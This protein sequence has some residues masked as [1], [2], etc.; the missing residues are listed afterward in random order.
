MDSTP[1][2]RLSE[3]SH[4]F[5]TSLRDK[6]TGGA[7]RPTRIPPGVHDPSGFNP[8]DHMTDDA[9]LKIGPPARERGK[10]IS[11]DLTP[12]E[13]ALAF[14]C[15]DDDADDSQQAP[16]ATPKTKPLHAVLA[17]HLGDSMSD[18]L[19]AYAGSLCVDG[20]RVGVIVADASGLRVSCVER[21]PHIDPHSE[22][23]A[24]V[25]RADDRQMRETLTE[26]NCDVDRWLLVLPSPK[27]GEARA[28]LKTVNA[29][30]LLCLTDHD[31]VTAAYRA[32]KGLADIGRPTV[33]VAPLR[34]EDVI[35]TE[36]AF[37]K[38]SSVCEQFLRLPLALGK[39]VVSAPDVAEHV[40]MNYTA[41]SD[42]A[43]FSAAPQWEVVSQFA[44]SAVRDNPIES[45]TSAPAAAPRP[46]MAIVPE[47]V[48]AAGP[49][50]PAAPI[51]FAS[52][53]ESVSMT[54]A[55]AAEG[56]TDVLELTGGATADAILRAVLQGGNDLAECPLRAPA[57]PEAVIAVARD[58]SLTLLAVARQGLNELRAIAI[59]YRWLGDNRALIA[60]ALPQF[61]TDTTAL[62]RLHLL[63]DQSDMTADIL[64]PLLAT[65][66]VTVRAYRKLRWGNK[67]GLLLD[68]A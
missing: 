36:T 60:M 57:C 8:M 11:I 44:A 66:N 26:L 40:V 59:A 27:S 65:G 17:Q 43:G 63:I 6:Q 39:K 42:D 14:A 1:N 3:I 24:A 28:L 13:F 45:A 33:T 58:R 32:L 52:V 38:L 41:S 64:R 49:V 5:L 34:D 55:P 7:A 30:T 23:P 19:L 21:N 50:P 29:W 2:R 9:P 48:V 20:G 10:D 47:T 16:A 67:T 62:P 22:E 18:H 25:S 15:P 35:S 53:A 56:F 37:T 4:L 46:V 68:A 54:I 51:S 12:E 61:A 31:G